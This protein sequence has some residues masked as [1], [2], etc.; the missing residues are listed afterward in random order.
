MRYLIVLLL[1][2]TAS[3][4]NSQKADLI[5]INANIITMDSSNTRAE[6]LAVAGDRVLAVGTSADIQRYAGNETE[7]I[8]AEGKTVVPGFNDAHIH[9]RPLYP[10]SSIYATVDLGPAHTPTMDD[11]VE[12]LA[13]KAALVPEGQWI[14]GINYQDTKLGRHPTR[15]DLD[16]ASTAHPIGI[17]HSSAHLAVY[18]SFAMDAAQLTADTE[19]PAGGQFDRDE[20]GWPNG[21]TRETAMAIVIQKS[22]ISLPTASI[23]EQADGLIRR[24]ERYASN[25]IT[26]VQDAGASQFKVAVWEAAF[27]KGLPVRAYV[28]ML[29]QDLEVLGPKVEAYNSPTSLLRFGAIKL[30]HGNSLSGRTCWLYE[31]YANRPDY[32]GIPPKWNQ[33]Q[34]NT[35]ILRVHEAGFQ[36]GIHSNGDREIDMVLDAFEYAFEKSPRENHRHRI[37]H[38]SIVNTSILERMVDLNIV[39][40]PHSYIYEHGDK[41]EA[42]GEAR[43]NMMHP[44]KS[45]LAYGIPAAGNSDAPVSEARP[46]LRLQSMVTRTSAEGKV[47]GPK[48]RVTPEEAI[49]LW[50]VG[51]AY[52]EFMD[53][54][55][56]TLSP[57]MLADFAILSANPTTFEPARIAEI[58]VEVTVVGGQRL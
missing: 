37:E 14:M 41:M 40:T 17:R 57:G 13:R 9:P 11:L 23:E 20:A 50:T 43:W 53:S 10:D 55:K 1:F 22:G 2:I 48:Q 16:R 7:V 25:G 52:S 45:A 35:Q 6:A 54:E 27:Q 12:A 39:L 8:D 49:Y 38:S 28:M 56:G 33:E 19:N 51:S 31:P 47:Y 34:L 58:D 21:I 5:V 46:M 32:F 18:N 4:A 24:L 36:V 29:P 15:E 26:S 42:Y 3:C 44:N 30:R